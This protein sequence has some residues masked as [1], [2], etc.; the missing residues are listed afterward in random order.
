MLDGFGAAA[1][2]PQ[3]QQQYSHDQQQQFLTNSFP[4]QQQQ[5]Q[6]R[7]QHQR[8]EEHQQ[9][10]HQP[11]DE[12][13]YTPVNGQ[14]HY[15]EQVQEQS[16][17]FAEG[18]GPAVTLQEKTFDGFKIP[19][20]EHFGYV[21]SACKFLG[22]NPD[23]LAYA[24]VC[25]EELEGV[26]GRLWTIQHLTADMPQQHGGGNGGLD[27]GG[28]GGGRGS[29]GGGGGGRAPSPHNQFG[30]WRVR[31]VGALDRGVA[32]IAAECM[33]G[34]VPLP[35]DAVVDFMTDIEGQ[36]SYFEKLVAHSAVLSWGND[37]EL[38]LAPNGYLVHGG[39]SPDKGCGDIQVVKALVGLKTRYPRQV[40][41]IFGTVRVLRQKLTLEDTIEFHAFAPLEA[42]PCV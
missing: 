11:G 18:E 19:R 20:V 16:T 12:S 15:Q 30:M 14:D 5:Q 6:Y 33:A 1:I 29:P 9:A 36:W 31:S 10:A 39:D 13:E 24:Q 8:E 37:G 34:R 25:D 4:H 40:F 27:G 41:L 35:T 28:G 23:Q 3:Q 17:T 26:D 21:S 22:V 7:Q 38:Q 42:V 2:H 32:A